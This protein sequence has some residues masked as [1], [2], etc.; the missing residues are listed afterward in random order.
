[1]AEE[2]SGRKK[3]YIGIIVVLLIYLLVT[4]VF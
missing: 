1:M 3:W 2:N 4:Q